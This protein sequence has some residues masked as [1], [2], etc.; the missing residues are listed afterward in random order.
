MYK[1]AQTGEGTWLIVFVVML[2]IIG[3]GLLWGMTA[4]FGVEY[5]FRGIDAEI[6]NFKIQ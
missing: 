6:L 1:K 3:L 4:F 2:A 5:D